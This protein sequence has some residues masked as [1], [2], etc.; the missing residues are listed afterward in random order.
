MREGGNERSGPFHG[1]AVRG[2]KRRGGREYHRRARNFG[3]HCNYVRGHSTR[4]NYVPAFCNLVR[5]RS[6]SPTMEQESRFFPSFPAM[7]MRG[8]LP[9]KRCFRHERTGRGRCRPRETSPGN[10]TICSCVLGC[11]CLGWRGR[12]RRKGRRGGRKGLGRSF[13]IRRLRATLVS[14]RIFEDVS[15]NSFVGS[16]ASVRPR[17]YDSKAPVPFLGTLSPVLPGLFRRW[18]HKWVGS[19]FVNGPGCVSVM[20]TTIGEGPPTPVAVRFGGPWFARVATRAPATSCEGFCGLCFW[21]F[22]RLV[23]VDGRSMSCNR[24]ISFRT[25]G[26]VPF[27]HEGEKRFRWV[28]HHNSCASDHCRRGDRWCHFRRFVPH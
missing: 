28:V 14:S 3:Y 15:R 26:F 16:Y 7:V 5:R 20:R 8:G 1:R 13:G 6:V 27:P 12:R 17:G 2:P 23:Y 24:T 11:V 19:I 4:V 18:V 9:R 10:G 21:G 22:V 25:R